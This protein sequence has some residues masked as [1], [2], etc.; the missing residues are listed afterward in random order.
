MEESFI[1]TGGDGLLSGSL[2]SLDGKE[3]PS[4]DRYM[5]L[6]NFLSLASIKIP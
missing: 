5:H 4:R 2:L 1:G 6:E 3:G